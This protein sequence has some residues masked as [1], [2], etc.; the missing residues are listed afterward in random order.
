VTTTDTLDLS[1][2]SLDDFLATSVEDS[3]FASQVVE[4]S[5]LTEAAVTDLI[6]D[7]AGEARLAC[8]LLAGLEPRRGDRILEVGAGPGIFAAFLHRQ[9]ADVFA[10]E[11]IVG[12]FESSMAV[13][14]V[15]AK[16]VAMPTIEPLGA[17]QLS[18]DEHGQFD[19]IFSVNVLEHMHP[20]HRNLDAMAAV[21]AP[22]G[23]M[24]HTCPNY[25]I[26]YEPH[27]RLPLVPGR[28]PLTRHIARKA[29]A[30]P[31]WASLNW[32]TAGDIRSFADR[33]G[34]R[35][36][37]NEG[38]L[39]KALGRLRQDPAFSRRQ[40]G[41]VV[42]TLRVLD[43]VGV[44]GLLTRIPATIMTPMTFTLTRGAD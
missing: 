3:A 41:P 27:Y 32:I 25:R 22:G 5:G 33:N 28:P 30:Q 26:P 20:L 8:Q 13:R 37:F 17:E 42:G 44:A 43:K 4:L 14:T 31:L 38:E 2:S 7:L 12:G 36:T 15:L 21:L 16:Y 6:D 9:G 29:S 23:R 39:A 19:L 1:P 34:L 11:P 35:V 24:I 40:R 10:I 18:Q